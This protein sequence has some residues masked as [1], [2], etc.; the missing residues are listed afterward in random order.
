MSGKPDTAYP[1]FWYPP[2]GY[3]LPSS[4]KTG[5]VVA[6]KALLVQQRRFLAF[7]LPF[8]HPRVKS[9]PVSAALS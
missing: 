2:K 3:R 1:P 7:C 8:T 9:A 4:N 5:H 6:L